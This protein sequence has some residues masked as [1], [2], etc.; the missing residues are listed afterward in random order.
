M[1]DALRGKGGD[2]IRYFFH[3]VHQPFLIFLYQSLQD[4]KTVLTKMQNSVE[5]IKNSFMN[6]FLMILIILLCLE[7]NILK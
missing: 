7:L 6:G 1:E 3:E 2:A 4:Y 5:A